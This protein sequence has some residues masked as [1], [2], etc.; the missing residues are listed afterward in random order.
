MARARGQS[1]GDGMKTPHSI[2][3]KVLR[4]VRCMEVFSKL[5]E[6]RANTSIADSRGRPSLHNIRYLSPRHLPL[7]A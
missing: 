1:F 2:S 3:L 7:T 4:W 5:A 6:K